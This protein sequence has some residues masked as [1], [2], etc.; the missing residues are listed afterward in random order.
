M[1]I[2][3]SIIKV[4]VNKQC[5][6]DPEQVK[7]LSDH[8]EANPNVLWLEDIIELS[9]PRE[10][11]VMV[12]IDKPEEITDPSKYNALQ[13]RM[14]NFES[15]VRESYKGDSKF[16]LYPAL[17]VYQAKHNLPTTDLKTV[18]LDEENKMQ[19]VDPAGLMLADLA[20]N[21]H[22][23]DR[24]YIS[25]GRMITKPVVAVWG[26]ARLAN[27]ISEL[28]RHGINTDTGKL[29]EL[30][31]KIGYAPMVLSKLVSG[32]IINPSTDLLE[33][34]AEELGID[35]KDITPHKP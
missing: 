34:I 7:A 29:G 18:G 26:K 30:A 14:S 28:D 11:A 16:T 32:C 27:M 19:F 35:V 24:I 21:V 22:K 5:A 13:E 31:R 20:I 15:I 9:T 10:I 25:R 3:N 6:P 4:V 33:A 8:I 2:L 23:D 17:R 1:T 12:V